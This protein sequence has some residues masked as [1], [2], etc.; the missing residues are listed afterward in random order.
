MTKIDFYIPKI[1][2]TF[3]LIFS[4]IGTE[5]TVF[6]RHKALTISAFQTVAE[7]QDLEEKAYASLES[8]FQSRSNSTSIPAE[9]FLSGIDREDLKQAILDSVSHA[10]DYL[11]GKSESYELIMPF[12][13]LEASVNQFFSDYADQHNYQKDE[14]YQQKVDAA[15]SEA[16]AEILFIAD[17]FKLSMMYE[18]GWLAK[19]KKLFSMLDKITAVLCGITGILLIL[20]IICC[21]KAFS[22]FWYWLGLIG[23]ISGLLIS[24]P[25]L[26]IL[27]TDYFSG[28]V[29]REPQIFAAVTGYLTFMTDQICKTAGIT[30]ITGICLLVIF[31]VHSRKKA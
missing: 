8:Y 1:L 3:L 31:A 23:L 17:T 15:I 22:D 18:K 28:F 11:S 13:D 29:V 16:E 4:L 19:G 26:Y 10:F 9:V 21:R 30:A 25:C 2:L 6:L 24:V 20:L 5:L 12:T 7:T 27:R 14:I